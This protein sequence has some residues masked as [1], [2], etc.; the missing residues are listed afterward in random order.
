MDRLLDGASTAE[1]EAARSAGEVQLHEIQCRPEYSEGMSDVPGW[2]LAAHGEWVL[3]GAR[4]ART[5]RVVTSDGV[6]A[7]T[8]L[9]SGSASLRSNG[10]ASSPV[11]PQVST[12]TGKNP[13]ACPIAST[14]L[15]HLFIFSASQRTAAAPVVLAAALTYV[16]P[17]T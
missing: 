3:S 7:S 12:Q 15:R 14:L 17:A 5:A 4:C 9:S 6:A 8:L 11:R 1:F 2:A 10:M 13:H 16:C